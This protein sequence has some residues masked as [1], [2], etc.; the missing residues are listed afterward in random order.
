MVKKQSLK[1]K[2]AGRERASENS[3]RSA[4]SGGV[5]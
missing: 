5:C 4:T 3:R 1:M 2:A